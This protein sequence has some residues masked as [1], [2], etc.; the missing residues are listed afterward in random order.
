MLGK[1]YIYKH[2]N[3]GSK[4]F[5]ISSMKR[6][7]HIIYNYQTK[8]LPKIYHK[9]L[10]Q[11]YKKVITNAN[12]ETRIIILAILVVAYAISFVLGL[13]VF[14]IV[15]IVINSRVNKGLLSTR[16]GALLGSTTSF[17]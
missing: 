12:V 15:G 7:I 16:V 9:H 14:N 10:V 17:L 5:S 3:Y 6:M 1:P 11:T 4:N 13:A 2:S 8:T